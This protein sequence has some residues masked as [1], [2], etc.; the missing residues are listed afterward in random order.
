VGDSFGELALLYNLPRTATVRARENSL[1]WV[2]DRSSFSKILSEDVFESDD[3]YAW[4]GLHGSL[5]QASTTEEV[6]K[7]RRA[8]I[9]RED[10]VR[11]GLLGRGA[12]GI[13][14]LMRHEGTGQT[15]AMKS[16]SKGLVVKLNAQQ[17]VLNEKNIMKLIDSQFVVRLLCTYSTPQRLHFLME[18]VLGGELYTMYYEH[19][20]YGSNEHAK[21]YAACV[22]LALE[23]LHEKSIV[24]R[25]LK[26]ENLLLTE[27]G[28]LKLA[29]F[30]LAKVVTDKTYTVC[31]T[32]EY[33]AP[34][35]LTKTGYT[36]AV[37]WWSLGVLVFELMTGNVP[38]MAV[39]KPA[40]FAKIK[41]GIDCVDF[42]P[43]FHVGAE[44]FVRNL[45]QKNPCDRLPMLLGGLENINGHEWFSGFDW[46][47]MRNLTLMPPF[48][49]VVDSCTDLSNFTSAANAD[50]PLEVQHYD[51][52]STWDADFAT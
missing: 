14:E 2:I 52:G 23:H 39:C 51:N 40:I 30:G 34:E 20:L 10:L 3:I 43:T 15:Y 22:C 29:D 50:G 41:R 37:D 32:P 42:P 35:V 38:F 17:Q 4:D 31:G 5:D 28:H 48:R 26:A 49:P 33:M 18:P 8:E 46:N 36:C 16:L 25:D 9:A 21:Y 1:V 24:Y 13:V 44:A 7:V 11:I 47:S 45:M 19:G 12:F 6:H 27:H